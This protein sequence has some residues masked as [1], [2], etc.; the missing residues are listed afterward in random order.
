M[1]EGGRVDFYY[2]DQLQTVKPRGGKTPFHLFWGEGGGGSSPVLDIDFHVIANLK[3][4]MDH[5]EKN[6]TTNKK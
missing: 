5:T 1:G 6:K 3:N 4:I 2:S